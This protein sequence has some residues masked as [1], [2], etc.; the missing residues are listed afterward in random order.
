MI[1]ACADGGLICGPIIY[2][3]VV[4]LAGLFGW[5]HHKK[6]HCCESDHDCNERDQ[7]G[8]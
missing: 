1:L 2:A 4:G 3:A 6:H 5:R 8:E 7:A